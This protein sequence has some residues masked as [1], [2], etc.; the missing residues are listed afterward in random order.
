MAQHAVQTKSQ[1][2]VQE[3]M[4]SLLVDLFPAIPDTDEVVT[5]DTAVAFIAN[6]PDLA[7]EVAELDKAVATAVE[8]ATEVAVE[9][10]VETVVEAPVEHS[11]E[12]P[13][14][15]SVENAVET[16]VE[17]KLEVPVAEP[18]IEAVAAQVE[19]VAEAVPAL[20]PTDE[21]PV[22]NTVETGRV[23][24]EPPKAL[25]YPNA[26]AWA[27][28]SFDALLFDVCG[29][30]LAVPMEALGKIIKV[31]HETNHLI[32]RPEWFIGAYSETDQRLF[33]VDTAKY[34]MPEKGF[35]LAADGFDYIIQLQRTQWTLACKNVKT[36]VRLEPDQ[37]K[38]RSAQGKRKWLAGTVVEQMCALLHV[39]SLIE[40]LDSE[41]PQA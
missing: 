33:V 30:K 16:N 41:V 13:V 39:D 15:H 14:E 34:I 26:P 8:A 9:A 37:V 1:L 20:A 36:T 25:K 2:A 27:Q 32:G 24:G 12:A 29:L 21:T 6:E 19:P 40:L 18:Q 35:D 11:V 10:K 17:A 23:L 28:E 22:E 38:W 5:P 31:E 4:E 7:L 3:Y